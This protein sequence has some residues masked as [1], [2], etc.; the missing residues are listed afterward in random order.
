MRVAAEK[1]ILLDPLLAEAHDAL[2]IA[3]IR[4][5]RW[6]QSEQSFSRAIELDVT[7]P[8]SVAAFCEQ[9]PSCSVLVNNAGG[10]L[11]RD[12]FEDGNEDDWLGMYDSN[13]M[14]KVEVNP[15]PPAER[16]ND[17][18]L[19]DCA[20][21]SG[22]IRIIRMPTQGKFTIGIDADAGPPNWSE[23]QVVAAR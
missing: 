13:V 15:N 10:A 2:A 17:Q 8:A 18:C 20:G 3:H 22:R 12:R 14:G 6:E 21:Y 1:A 7:E 9:I 16:Q 11:G 4:D 5:G 19:G 23:A